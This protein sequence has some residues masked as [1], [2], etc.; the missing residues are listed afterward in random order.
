MF[1]I[2]KRAHGK[3]YDL[4]TKSRLLI[5]MSPRSAQD[6]KAFIDGRIRTSNMVTVTAFQPYQKICGETVAIVT[7]VEVARYLMI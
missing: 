4:K 2:D 1:P 3:A 6:K 7:C 5:V